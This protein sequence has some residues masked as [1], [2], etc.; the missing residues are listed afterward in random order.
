MERTSHNTDPMLQRESDK[1]AS[2]WAPDYDPKT[3]FFHGTDA[4]TSKLPYIADPANGPGAE[5]STAFKSVHD[6]AGPG[7]HNLIQVAGMNAHP[8]TGRVFI[9]QVFTDKSPVIY[10]DPENNPQ[11][12]FNSFGRHV[13]GIDVPSG[14]EPKGG[15]SWAKQLAPN[16]QNEEEYK[17]HTS[18]MNTLEKHQFH[19]DK[20]R[21][22]TKIMAD[23]GF[24]VGVHAFPKE[25][26]GTVV[27]PFRKKYARI[28][29][30]IPASEI[31]RLG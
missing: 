7:F 1:V 5:P 14:F 22:F 21:K 25:G 15:I 9:S 29:G 17:Q 19:I 20:A 2:L 6:Y 10:G 31:P 23:R 3:L 13:K 4:K 16:P 12:S 28:I 18:K 8:Q 11:E 27:R 26:A 30:E 24:G